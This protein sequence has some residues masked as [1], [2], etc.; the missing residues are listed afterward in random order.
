MKDLDKVLVQLAKLLNSNLI[1]W[2]V[3][4]SKLLRLSG[5]ELD[6]NDLDIMI[7]EHDFD[8]CIELLKSVS[9]ECEVKESEIFK[10]K[11]YRKLCWDNVQID[12]MSG[13]T[14]QLN[15]NVFVYEFDCKDKEILYENISIPLCFL[16]DWYVLYHVMPHREAKI[17]I[18]EM[19]FMNHT[20]QD[21]R[22]YALLELNIPMDIRIKMND[23]ENVIMKKRLT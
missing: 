11:N 19:F 1:N 15:E 12:C 22:Y 10:S 18:M 21:R 13:M 16:E 8:R 23:F 6:V 3:G 5:M 4:G 14:I 2:A 7:H 17:K 9:I 20:I